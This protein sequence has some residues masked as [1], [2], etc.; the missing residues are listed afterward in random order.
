M[1]KVVIYSLVLVLALSWMFLP[2]VWEN[3]AVHAQDAAPE[4]KR[5]RPGVITAGTR[6]FTIRLDG[7]HFASGANVLFDGV[8]LPAPRISTKGRV[9][10][11]EVSASLIASPGTHT[12]QASNSAGVISALG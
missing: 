5:V 7:R 11:A 1:R 3:S 6:T 12:V 2:G 10:L 8:A 9:L 4:L